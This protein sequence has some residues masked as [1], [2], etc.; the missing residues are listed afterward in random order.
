MIMDHNIIKSTNLFMKWGKKH[1]FIMLHVCQT[2]ITQA[3]IM[4][5]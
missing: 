1:H 3:G 4:F 5:P 2:K